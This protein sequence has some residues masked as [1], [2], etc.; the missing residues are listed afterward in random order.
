MQ[1]GY[2]GSPEQRQTGRNEVKLKFNL[3][4]GG[5]AQELR[6][7]GDVVSSI[8]LRE[9]QS[10]RSESFSSLCG[11]KVREILF[12]PGHP[13]TWLRFR[14][15]S[16]PFILLCSVCFSSGVVSAARVYFVGHYLVGPWGPGFF[17]SSKVA[18]G[19]CAAIQFGQGDWKYHYKYNLMVQINT[20][21]ISALIT[22]STLLC[23]FSMYLSHFVMKLDLGGWAGL[24]PDISKHLKTYIPYKRDIICYCSNIWVT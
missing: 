7:L 9:E 8:L 6:L 1:E 19:H 23:S 14:T 21:L 18:L 11:Y 15:C 4:T 5:E 13:V 20:Y 22:L 24:I 3:E 12:I 10:G 2:C 16:H 17:I